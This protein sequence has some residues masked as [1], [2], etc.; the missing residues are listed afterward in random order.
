[1]IQRK[2]TTHRAAIAVSLFGLLCTIYL[3]SYSGVFHSTDEMLYVDNAIELVQGRTDTVGHGG[4]FVL[5]CAL[6]FGLTQSIDFVGP[7]QAIFLLN[8]PAT[9]ITA[10]FLFG[11]VV[12]LGYGKRTALLTALLYGL[13]TPAWVYSKTLFRE[14]L[15][16]AGLMAG[17]YFLARFRTQFSPLPLALALV[18]LGMA[19]TTR[20]STAAVLPFAY[21]YLCL[22]VAENATWVRNRRQN[23]AIVLA[24]VV[25]LLLIL[26][27]LWW[28]S[29]SY[30]GQLDRLLRFFSHGDALLALLFSPGRG[31][32]LFSPLLL[33]SLVG[34]YAFSRRHPWEAVV[35]YG[36]STCYAIIASSHPIWWGGWN[37]GPRFLISFLPL[38]FVPIAPIVQSVSLR[39]TPWLLV[40][41]AALTLF[42][43]SIQVLAVSVG[44][45]M[46]TFSGV[47]DTGS[48]FDWS[49]SPWATSLSELR[50]L[51]LDLGW[52]NLADIPAQISVVVP[53]LLIILLCAGFLV[54][55]EIRTR[56]IGSSEARVI[57]GHS[58]PSARLVF[59]SLAGILGLVLGTAIWSMHIFYTLDSRYEATSGF[60]EAIAEVKADAQAGDLLVADYWLEDGYRMS[61]RLV[62]YCRGECPPSILVAREVWTSGQGREELLAEMTSTYRRVWLIPTGLGPVDPNSV[63]ELALDSNTFGAG[64]DWAG[65]ATRLCLYYNLPEQVVAGLRHESNL[66]VGDRIRLRR[67]EL[68]WTG[69][70]SAMQESKVL[71]S[72]GDTLFVHLTW[73]ALAPVEGRY[74]VSI[75]FQD[76]RHHIWQQIDREP[77]AGFQPTDS[78]SEG[79]L[80]VDR[81]ALSLPASLAP[82]DYQLV[83]V[84]YDPQT[85]S[86]LATETG[87]RIVLADISLQ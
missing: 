78:W 12:E 42:S 84:L 76:P 52:A 34:L 48:A 9:A 4:P 79:E 23:M 15:A 82:G 17:I 72:P 20:T 40:L 81:Y 75:Q 43:L 66:L 5:A 51:R 2:E 87:D 58:W 27:T 45:E 54:L 83:L 16:A 63:V 46:S 21:V 7:L 86:R 57:A 28:V 64:C 70:R 44:P 6:I 36:S 29:T 67:W 3:L 25:L 68:Y 53:N 19:V 11:F 30:L 22:A 65:Q 24:L 74:K 55:P 61:S 39:R 13:A 77:V 18:S 1:M 37:W 60:P 47:Q 73:E 31:M 14:P 41:L 49:F 50:Q 8:I 56:R 10:L 69:A 32:F 80:V 35:L 59:L 38:M 62:N 85:S 33:L 71:A 26:G